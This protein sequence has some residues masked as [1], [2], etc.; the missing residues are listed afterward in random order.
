MPACAAENAREM[1]RIRETG[2][3]GGGELLCAQNRVETQAIQVAGV[4]GMT[5]LLL[6]GRGEPGQRHSEAACREVG[7]DNQMPH[8]NLAP[9][10][11]VAV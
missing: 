7:N 6:F 4:L 2:Q 10:K 5:E 1:A 3:V 11:D 9:I 8:G